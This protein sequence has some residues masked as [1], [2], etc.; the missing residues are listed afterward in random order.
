ML[1]YSVHGR[2][3]TKRHNHSFT[4]ETPDGWQIKGKTS[5]KCWPTVSLQ[6]SFSFSDTDIDSPNL[7]NSTEGMNPVLPKYIPLMTV[8]QNAAKDVN[9]K[10]TTGLSRVQIWWLR[11]APPYDS[12]HS[13]LV[14][15]LCPL[16]RHLH[17][18]CFSSHLFP[19]SFNLSPTC[20]CQ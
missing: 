1:T 7:L 16:W 13:D 10:S 2:H 11:K 9:L 20:A 19:V 17:L 14:T 5:T 12:H 4:A 18:L 15:H 8:V 3:E 6:G